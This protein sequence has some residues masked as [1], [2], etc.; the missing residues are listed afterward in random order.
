MSIRELVSTTIL[1]RRT[2]IRMF[3]AFAVVS[4]V[5]LSV[6]AGDQDPNHVVPEVLVESL[7]ETAEAPD[8]DLLENAPSPSPSG[9]QGTHPFIPVYKT[10]E[11]T[12]HVGGSE[13]EFTKR[14]QAAHKD[15]TE[16][17]NQVTL[18]K[19]QAEALQVARQVAVV[20]GD[21]EQMEALKDKV[22][23][24]MNHAAKKAKQFESSTR[25]HDTKVT[26]LKHIKSLDEQQRKNVEA[27][28]AMVD[29]EK[30]ARVKTKEAVKTAS[31][32]EADA[33]YEAVYKGREYTQAKEGAI[34]AD[35][36]Y[37]EREKNI[38]DKEYFA[39][40]AEQAVQ[41]A[42][43]EKQAKNIKETAMKDAIDANAVDPNT[44]TAAL[45]DCTELPEEY[46]SQ[47]GS[48]QDC[49][50]WAKDGRCDQE[51]Y[52]TFMKQ[53][54]AASC[55]KLKTTGALSKLEDAKEETAS[56]APAAESK[57]K[58]D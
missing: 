44:D 2:M 48:C 29:K 24:M 14:Y 35:E 55:N 52:G 41:K 21:A 25:T 43:A 20:R 38:Q 30:K 22:T 12:P 58:S 40:V 34:S 33:R 36:N 46:A 13:E 9:V 31:A 19:D 7:A 37:H 57:S 16:A 53:Y 32:A 1:Q 6:S 18:A 54:C 56:A 5:A 11:A 17:E 8:H 39:K 15:Q 28:E 49:S 51:A 23:K 10:V 45:K 27:A 47:G 4:V 50:K 3:I 26:E 42:A